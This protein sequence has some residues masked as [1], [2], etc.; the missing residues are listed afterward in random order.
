[1]PS[2]LSL[3]NW[4]DQGIRAVKE[5]PGRL[6]AVKQAIPYIRSPC[7]LLDVPAVNPIKVVCLDHEQVRAEGQTAGGEAFCVSRRQ[8][9]RIESR[10][11]FPRT[12]SSP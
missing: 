10:S 12:G 5:S 1:M 3:I 6:D 8:S 7:G 2:Y 9:P 4:T 11:K